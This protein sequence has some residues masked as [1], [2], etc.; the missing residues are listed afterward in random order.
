MPTILSPSVQSVFSSAFAN[1]SVSSDFKFEYRSVI[2]FL[3]KEGHSVKNIYERMV[4]VY[5]HDCPALST[6]TRW[7]NEFKRG[8]VNVQDEARP[9]RPT[10]S[11]DSDHATQAEALIL[12]NRRIKVSEVAMGLGISYGSAST[13]IHDILRMSKVSARWVPRNLSVQDR[14][15][16]LSSCQELLDLFNQ[17]P[18]DFMARLVTGDETWLYQWDPETKQQSMQWRHSDSPP[19]KKFKTQRSARKVMATIFWDAKGILLIDYLDIGSTITGQYYAHVIKKL[20]QAIVEKRRGMVTRGVLLLHDNAPVHKSR[21]A[22]AAI[23]DCGFE[24]LDHPPYSPD[25]APSDYFLFPNLKR[26]LKGTR[27]DDLDSLKAA[28]EEWF[29][30]HEESF[31]SRGICMLKERWNK[32]IDVRGDYV[33]K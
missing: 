22:Q 21:V 10:T 17:D 11:T 25:L 5:G 28:T 2:K 4:N 29:Q 3:Y 24:Q 19:P 20:R 33:E 7:F 18:E 12:A 23:R 14:H 15:H 27:F 1:M 9:G 13:I 26:F 6:V 31:F 8:R 30:D 32:C 16:R